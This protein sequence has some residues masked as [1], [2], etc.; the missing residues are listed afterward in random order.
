MAAENK[1]YPP[2]DITYYQENGYDPLDLIN[3]LQLQIFVLRKTIENI[4][5]K[6]KQLTEKLEN[7]LSA[8]T[9]SENTPSEKKLE[10]NKSDDSNSRDL[11]PTCGEHYIRVLE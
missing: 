11:C 1:F 3:D 7:N 4:D 6:F 2:L 5:N 10:E 9:V 8:K